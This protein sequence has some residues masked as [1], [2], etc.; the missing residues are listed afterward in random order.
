MLRTTEPWKHTLT[1]CCKGGCML[2]PC[3][4][5]VSLVCLAGAS[6][7]ASVLLLAFAAAGTV[8]RGGRNTLDAHRKGTVWLPGAHAA[9]LLARHAGTARHTT[10]CQHLVLGAFALFV[11]FVPVH[12]LGRPLPQECGTCRGMDGDGDR[13]GGC[14]EGLA[15]GH[16]LWG[17][18]VWVLAHRHVCGCACCMLSP[19]PMVVAAS[20]PARHLVV[21]AAAGGGCRVVIALIVPSTHALL[22]EMYAIGLLQ[23]L[24]VGLNMLHPNV[25]P[26]GLV[27]VLW[28]CCA[29]ATASCPPIRV[30]SDAELQSMLV[31]DCQLESSMSCLDVLPNT[32]QAVLQR[33]C[34][35]LLPHLA[36]RLV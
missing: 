34:V 24:I 26:A 21:V 13:R 7:S 23:G 30:L 22:A 33:V 10:A 15:T 17:L 18:A 3:F 19:I 8:P 1:S 6:R 2:S 29:P 5:L 11:Q 20:I 31:A 25:C 36:A 27:A 4:A 28:T 9:R 12:V 14:H 32:S 16:A 35:G